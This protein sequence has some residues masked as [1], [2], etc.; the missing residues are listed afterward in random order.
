MTDDAYTNIMR[1]NA[2][3]YGRPLAGSKLRS[4]FSRFVDQSSTKLRMHVQE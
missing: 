4:Y 2:Q 1:G 3:R